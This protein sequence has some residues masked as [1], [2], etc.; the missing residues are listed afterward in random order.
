MKAEQII[1][2]KGSTKRKVA[3]GVGITIAIVIGYFVFKKVSTP[4]A[5]SAKDAK[6]AKPDGS[7]ATG[8]ATDSAK[9]GPG[10]KGHK[11]GGGSGATADGNPP[12]DGTT[13]Q[14]GISQPAAPVPT[15]P[16]ETTAINFVAAMGAP[17][18][19]NY[20]PNQI[21]LNVQDAVFPIGS[22]VSLNH[23]SYPSYTGQYAVVALPSSG[24]DNRQDML[25]NIPYNDS[26]G[27][28]NS[29]YG[30]H[31][32]TTPGGTVSLVGLPADN[33]TPLVMP[34]STDGLVQGANPTPLT[35]SSF[36]GMPNENSS[37]EFSYFA[38]NIKPLGT[39]KP[40]VVKDGKRYRLFTVQEAAARKKAYK[41]AK[42]LKLIGQ[43]LRNFI[44][45]IFKF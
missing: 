17:T 29:E 34:A 3:I 37:T 32:D 5:S 4:A 10:G 9:S 43:D 40:T 35:G 23:P 15:A 44:S 28:V 21:A 42:G 13:S 33:A 27:L 8:A 1:G 19:A 14:D 39:L 22:L 24:D 12:S 26:I 18:D 16:G 25:L 6:G 11:G 30:V 36:E 20:N 7:I 2:A 45:K 31:W 38:M 41:K